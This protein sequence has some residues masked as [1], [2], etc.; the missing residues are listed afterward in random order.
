MFRRIVRLVVHAEDESGI[1]TVRRRGD[2]DFFYRR[3]EVL[4][5][6]HALGKEAGGLDHDVR[7][8][9]GPVNLGGVFYLENF[10]TPAFDGGGVLSMRDVMGPIAEGPDGF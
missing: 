7:A 10:K 6:V 4:L 2:D 9:G 5:G 1:G 3:A 8:D